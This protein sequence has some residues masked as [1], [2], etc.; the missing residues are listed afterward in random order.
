MLE[1][2]TQESHDFSH[3]RFKKDN[4][5]EGHYFLEFSHPEA[6]KGMGLRLWAELVGCKPGE[7]TVFG[8]NLNDTGMFLEA[9]RKVAVANEHPDI[10]LIADEIVLSNEEDGVA[11]YIADSVGLMRKN[12]VM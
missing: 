5:I 9:G 3:E 11:G 4:Y 7:V 1:G 2:T 12:E 8:D 10:L 6:N